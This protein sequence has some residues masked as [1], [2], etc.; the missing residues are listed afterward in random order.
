MCEVL[1]HALASGQKTQA[2]R[3]MGHISI[4][5]MLGDTAG[6]DGG[7]AGRRSHPPVP[8]GEWERDELLRREK[9]TLGLYVSSHPLA[10]VKEQ[11]ARRS[12][13]PLSS[14]SSLRDGQV[15]T[16]GGL[17]AGLK[18]LV[19]KKGDQMAFVELDDTTGAI[20]VVVFANTLAASRALL[21]PDS[22]VMV[23]GRVD[24]KSEGE[25]KLVAFE[26]AQFEPT[27]N[28]GVVKLRLNGGRLRATV[29][30]DLKLLIGEF[31]GEAPV[32]L[33]VETSE[34]PKTLRFGPGYKVR[35]DSDFFA[36]AKALLG[37]AAMIA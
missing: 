4:F 20:E 9:E 15:V 1:E 37:D 21:Q 5:D 31:P 34:G 22:I 10:D 35:A 2:D 33:E 13:C 36:E 32:V 29:I 16:V 26:V 25:V 24:H 28:F 3:M 7:A 12:D 17:V 11:L 30:E 27:A 6:I 23:K 19:T 8:T 18:T 14:F